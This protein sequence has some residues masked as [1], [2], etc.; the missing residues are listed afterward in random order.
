MIAAAKKNVGE[1]LFTAAANATQSGIF[2]QVSISRISIQG[3]QRAILNFTPGP[4]SELN[5]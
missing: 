3:D 2:E 5:P 4:R 1:S